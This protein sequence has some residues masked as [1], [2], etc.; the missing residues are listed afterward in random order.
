MHFYEQMLESVYKEEEKSRYQKFCKNAKKSY[1]GENYCAY[2][3]AEALIKAKQFLS[4]KI[5]SDSS[6]WLWKNLN[7]KDYRS[8]ADYQSLLPWWGQ[9]LL[10]PLLE[11]SVGVPGN[12]NTPNY[13]RMNERLSREEKVVMSSTVSSNFKMVVQ[14]DSKQEKS[15]FSIDS[16]ISGHP[17][18]PDVNIEHLNG[19]LKPMKSQK[20]IEDTDATTLTLKPKGKYNSSEYDFAYVLSND[21]EVKKTAKELEEKVVE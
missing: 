17:L 12:Q 3:V 2:N 19:H 8:G 11:T 9:A 5:S 20:E 6:K 1:I 15:S 14:F 10:K 18:K 4:Q 13:V 21:E 16:G 7:V